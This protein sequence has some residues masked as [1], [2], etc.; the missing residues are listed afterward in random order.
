MAEANCGT[1]TEP[2][3]I[4][5][6]PAILLIMLRGPTR[7]QGE[8]GGSDHSQIP[9]DLCHLHSGLHGRHL[10]RLFQKPN[11]LVFHYAS[12]HAIELHFPFGG[13]P[14]GYSDSMKA[15]FFLVLYTV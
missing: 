5:E 10:S 9:G 15:A 13:I 11:G 6:S 1:V 12:H 2:A 8:W 14:W 7:P 4:E 3:A